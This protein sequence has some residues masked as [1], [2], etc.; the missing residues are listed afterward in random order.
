VAGD[1]EGLSVVELLA[2]LRRV[3]VANVDVEDGIPGKA[4]EAGKGSRPSAVAA[5]FRSQ[6]R[7]TAP[8]ARPRR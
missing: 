1:D 6:Y 2:E 4:L 8:R 7:F 3:A 5:A